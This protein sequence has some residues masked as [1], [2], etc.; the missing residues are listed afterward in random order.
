MGRFGDA[1]SAMTH[2]GDIICVSGGSG[3]VAPQ[4][5]VVAELSCRRNVLDPLIMILIYNSLTYEHVSFTYIF[6]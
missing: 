4:K 5:K 3:G 6:V 1:V 2:F